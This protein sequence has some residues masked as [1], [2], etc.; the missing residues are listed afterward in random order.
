[1]SLARL[2]RHAVK[3]WLGF[4]LVQKLA[5]LLNMGPTLDILRD[6]TGAAKKVRFGKLF[7]NYVSH[8]SSLL[9]WQLFEVPTSHIKLVFNDLIWFFN[10]EKFYVFV[11]F[12]DWAW[13]NKR[14]DNTMA[15]IHCRIT[16]MFLSVAAYSCILT[17]CLWERLVWTRTAC[18]S[19]M[20]IWGNR[21][22]LAKRW[23]Q[24]S[25]L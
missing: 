20:I 9:F 23:H 13:T 22:L 12:T 3:L 17:N 15:A 6:V 4:V 21:W 18:L 8:W 25:F 1:M 24:H 2:R 5:S 10:C 14:V 16:S 19:Y 7:T 11:A